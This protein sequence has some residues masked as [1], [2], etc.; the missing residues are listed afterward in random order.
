MYLL[1]HLLRDMVCVWYQCS[2]DF[3]H[4]MEERFDTILPMFFASATTM[5]ATGGCTSPSL[6]IDVSV[7]SS[8]DGMVDPEYD[9]SV[10]KRS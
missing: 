10:R 6:M 9:V 5:G 8:Q 3:P 2:E 7:V 1:K 4:S